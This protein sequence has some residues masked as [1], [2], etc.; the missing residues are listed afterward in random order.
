M[1]NELAPVPNNY[2]TVLTD[3][4]RLAYSVVAEAR[5]RATTRFGLRSTSGGFGTPPWGDDV[6]VRI[7]GDQIIMEE[8]GDNRSTKITTLREAAAFVGVEPGTEPAEHDSPELGDI[9]APLAVGASE[10][11]FLGAWFA[12]A[13]K[14]LEELRGLD[15]AIDP[16]EVQLWPGHFD[17]ATAI[18]DVEA[19]TR[20]T[21]GFSPGDGG[22][23]E[24]YIYV[25]AWGEIDRSNPY[26]NEEHFNG[27]SLGYSELLASD[28]PEATA[29]AF[30][31]TG[32]DLL[33]G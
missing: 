6:R 29:R 19:G 11:A 8:G 10:T 15:G 14:L 16:D 25:G 23:P 7:E 28:D 18:G 30:L 3:Y 17:P 4:H 31:R 1:S 24:P 21:Y 22:H 33:N 32:Y 26:W 5:R 2:A 20:A 27:A 9:D 13:T 12:L